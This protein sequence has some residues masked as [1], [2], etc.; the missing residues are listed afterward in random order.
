MKN[1]P[2]TANCTS[3]WIICGCGAKVSGIRFEEFL[4]PE[5]MRKPNAVPFVPHGPRLFNFKLNECWT[6]SIIKGNTW[7]R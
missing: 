7:H 6:C 2:K 3:E 1:N 4:W 5:W